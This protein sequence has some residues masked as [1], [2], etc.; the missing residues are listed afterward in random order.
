MNKN[1]RVDVKVEGA[2]TFTLSATFHAFPLLCTLKLC[3]GGNLLSQTTSKAQTREK[4]PQGDATCMRKKKGTTET[5][6]RRLALFDALAM[7]NFDWLF[8]K[9][10][11]AV[12]NRASSHFVSVGRY[13]LQT[14]GMSQNR[15]AKM[16]QPF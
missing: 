2:S 11:A 6:K 15:V 13:G 5:K 4:S 3:N 16:L 9:A 10:K 8:L 1:S 7:Q 14:S 12:N